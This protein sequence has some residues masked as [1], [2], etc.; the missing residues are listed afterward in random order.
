MPGCP[1]WSGFGGGG[2][3]GC[4][5]GFF[6]EEVFEARDVGGDL[7]GGR[8]AREAR[9]GVGL[10]SGAVVEHPEVGAHEFKGFDGLGVV[11]RFVGGAVGFYQRTDDE[12]GGDV[13]GVR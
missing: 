4:P 1:R 3:R 6:A 9:G 10:L 13:G 7:F 5:R 8:A 11:F 2:G 12:L